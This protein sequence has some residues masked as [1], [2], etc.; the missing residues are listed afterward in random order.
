[1]HKPSAPACERN[2][3]F[4]LDVL[5]TAFKHV[6][7]VLEVG[8]GTGQHAVFFAK[9]LP[10][11]QWHPSEKDGDF[12]GMQLWI[13]ESGL[14]NIATPVTFNVAS[15]WPLEKACDGMFTAN[16]LHIMSWEHVVAFFEKVGENLSVNGKLCV[17]GPFNY[18]GEYTSASN[19]EFDQWL[20]QRDLKSAIRNFEE[21]QS[22]A[23]AAGLKL[24]NDHE[25]P[26]NNRLLEWVKEH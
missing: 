12:E 20:K 23:E 15:E 18:G 8:S 6:K 4:I 14:K 9:H 22:L 17:Y 11:L 5:V 2:K 26:A 10:Q 25:M 24:I 16:T 1:M 7:N 13:N 19:A 21:I 3:Q